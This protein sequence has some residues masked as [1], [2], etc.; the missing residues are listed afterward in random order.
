MLNVDSER[1]IREAV[2]NNEYVA[3]SYVRELLEEVDRLR[4]LAYLGEHHFPDLTYKARLEET[5][6]DLREAQAQLENALD[7]S[8][9]GAWMARALD[10][11]RHREVLKDQLKYAESYMDLQLRA[12]KQECNELRDYAETVGLQAVTDASETYKVVVGERDL[13]EAELGRVKKERDSQHSQRIAA[14]HR[15]MV[16]ERERDELKAEI[17]RE[18]RSG[19]DLEWQISRI[20]EEIK[21]TGMTLQWTDGGGSKAPS[22]WARNPYL[23]YGDV[24]KERDLA[25]RELDELKARL[26]HAEADAEQAIHNEAFTERQRISAHLRTASRAKGVL[27]SIHSGQDIARLADDIEQGKHA[28]IDD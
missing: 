19:A 9:E 25:L 18:R 10:A 6:R 2:E 28:Q 1:E 22:G 13:A 24:A 14:E 12:V 27:I 5:V 21:R 3:L 8:K 26:A 4:K 17:E 23:N 11:E 20:E 16:A 7:A 15:A